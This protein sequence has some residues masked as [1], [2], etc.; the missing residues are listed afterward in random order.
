MNSIFEYIKDSKGHLIGVLLALKA[1]DDSAVAVS[2]SICNRR[3]RFD[4]ARGVGIAMTR[5]HYIL[6]QHRFYGAPIKSKR[7]TKQYD[8]FRARA[9]KYFRTDDVKI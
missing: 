8:A 1:A 3:D 2:W 4:K 5:A 9:M 7:I 6:T